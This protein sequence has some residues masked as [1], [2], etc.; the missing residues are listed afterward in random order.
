MSDLFLS[1]DEAAIQT[2]DWEILPRTEKICRVRGSVRHCLKYIAPAKWDL[3]TASG[4]AKAAAI[5]LVVMFGARSAT[6]NFKSQ[7]EP[8]STTGTAVHRSFARLLSHDRGR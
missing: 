1:A 8:R 6:I 2:L 7:P 4:A 5:T 3:C